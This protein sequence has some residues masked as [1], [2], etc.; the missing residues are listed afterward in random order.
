M[1]QQNI[2]TTGT[3][4]SLQSGGN[5]INANFTELYKAVSGF[6]TTATAA[7]TTTLTVNS[8][9]HQF[10][11]GTTTQTVTLPDATTLATG[12]SFKVHNDST[13]AVTINKNGGVGLFI[14]AGGTEA[15]IICTDISTAAGVWDVDYLG[16]AVA[17]GK[18][19]VQN[20][21]LTYQGTDGTTMTFPSTSATI[22]R[23]DVGQTFMGSQT[24]GTSP[25]FDAHTINGK[26]TLNDLRIAAIT[27][28]LPSLSY[29][30]VCFHLA[31]DDTYFGVWRKRK[32]QLWRSE[33][34]SAGKYLGVYAT[35]TTA[36]T[37]GGVLTDVYYNTTN[38]RFEEIT[39]VGSP[40][41]TVT[42]RAGREDYPTNAL[43]TAEAARV[44]IW[45][46]DGAQPS[47]WMTFTGSGIFG[48]AITSISILDAI[49]CVGT[50]G[51]GFKY[52]NFIADHAFTHQTAVTYRH[53]N[54][55]AI[56]NATPAGSYWATSLPVIANI[57][58]NDVAITILPDAPLDEYGMP[59]PNI[60]VATAGGVSEL[61]ND[62]T[63]KS[64]SLATAAY[65]ISYDNLNRIIWNTTTEYNCSPIPPRAA[66]FTAS[67][68]TE[69]N[70]SQAAYSTSN[71]PISP[72]IATATGKSVKNAIASTNGLTMYRAG[73]N[74]NALH[75]GVTSVFN[76]GWMVGDIRA[77]FY[78]NSLTVDRSI[79][80]LTLVT[81]GTVTETVNSGGRNVY[82]GYSAANY[83]QI[84]SNAAFNALGTGDFSITMS[85]VKWG[86]VATLK[87]LLTI[88][89]GAS[90]GS[91]ALE[92]LAA[93]TLCFYIWNATPTKTAI[94]TSTLTFTD[95]A[96][97]TIEVKRYTQA[98]VASTVAILVDG[99][100]VAS[101]VSTLTISNATGYLRIGE[102]Q[103][104]SN[105]WA[106]GFCSC[107]RISATAPTAEQSK[108]IAATENALNGGQTC[109]LSNSSS[110]SA[111][112]YDND[113]NTLLVGNGTN[114]D[115]FTNLKRIASAAHGVTTLTAL[116]AANGFKAVAGT[117]ATYTAPERNVEAELLQ[118][119][120]SDKK[121]I[122]KMLA[123]NANSVLYFPAGTYPTRV[124]SAAG[125]YISL[126]TNAPKTDGFLWYINSGL[127]AST[128]YDCELV[129][130]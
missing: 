21:S 27:A 114:V 124:T 97:H 7:G 52:V 63:S 51:S 67:S 110:V 81:V 46:L 9:Y 28:S 17:T 25:V 38:S 18:K 35:A 125:T 78:C 77:A 84:A 112:S 33:A 29:I 118:Q 83:S 113:T 12:F 92:H 13:G 86:T 22:A 122:T 103:D 47:M 2:D 55:P 54:I 89:N 120:P 117:G 61:L 37:A 31:K 20:N 123:S 111:L 129:R 39:N 102:G 100:V 40:A 126:S 6:T 59:V 34:R 16:I 10:F 68:A 30:D 66:S 42:Y 56:R 90:A 73:Q 65:G 36:I 48:T 127:A 76:T 26:S 14:L 95:T 108:F 107:V 105:P 70:L 24:V 32:G 49:L 79:S 80:A 104:A 99:V 91:I 11:T 128:N 87:K 8:T 98:G 75:A 119:F 53:I 88:G 58:C 130:T 64:S 5:K 71:V 1:A 109:L 115:T 93:N 3:T 101:A 15:E 45:D 121:P 50:T 62:G 19:V 43:I 96:E 60:A 94:C 106:G 41:S 57:N 72:A 44:I 85:G 74:S 82:S 69:P 116:A 4:D 23:T